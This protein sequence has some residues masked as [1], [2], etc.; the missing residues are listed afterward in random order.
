MR[1][2]IYDVTSAVYREDEV[3][4]ALFDNRYNSI[5]IIRPELQTDGSLKLTVSEPDGTERLYWLEKFGMITDEE[6]QAEVAQH[7]TRADKEALY[8]NLRYDLGKP[9]DDM[10]SFQLQEANAKIA[11]L[12]DERRQRKDEKEIVR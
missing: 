11:K 6:F 12:E 2:T 8:D 1:E 5:V 3:V 7:K 10:L 4:L 9:T